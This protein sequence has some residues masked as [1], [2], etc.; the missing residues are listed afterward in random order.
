M[1]L[2]SLDFRKEEM[3]FLFSPMIDSPLADRSGYRIS[4]VPTAPVAYRSKFRFNFPRPRRT[5]FERHAL[6]IVHRAYRATNPRPVINAHRRTPPTSYASLKSSTTGK[7]PLPLFLPLECPSFVWLASATIWR[8]NSRRD[9]TLRLVP[10]R[11]DTR[12]M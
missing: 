8:S 6:N 10:S 4:K 11:T 1:S 3:V 2:G 7:A 12:I 5:R 9:E